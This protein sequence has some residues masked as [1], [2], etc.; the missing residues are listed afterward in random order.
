MSIEAPGED[1]TTILRRKVQP[2]GNKKLFGT[3]GIRGEADKFP[4]DSPTVRAIG[5]S[6]ARHLAER[7]PGHAPRLIIG[8]DT[9][10]SSPRI[11]RDLIAGALA[12]GAEVQSPAIITPPR[13]PFPP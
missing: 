6:L 3:D 9:R 5:G 10:E 8:R 7:T 13:A 1:Q 12:S 11:E 2:K 4:L